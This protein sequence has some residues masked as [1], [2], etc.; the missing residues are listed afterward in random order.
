MLSTSTT[1][2]D[3]ELSSPVSLNFKNFQTRDDFLFDINDKKKEVRIF[4]KSLQGTK[5]SLRVISFLSC[6]A[7]IIILLSSE[8]K[9]LH[10][11][12]L[13]KNLDVHNALTLLYIGCATSAIISLFFTV[14]SIF[15]FYFYSSAKSRFFIEVVLDILNIISNSILMLHNVNLELKNEIFDPCLLSSLV[16]QGTSMVCWVTSSIMNFVTIER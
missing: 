1:N 3:V 4:E 12:T 15:P 14:S 16:F 6:V 5:I 11:L 10:S 9:N 13:E 2:S 7:A 8:T